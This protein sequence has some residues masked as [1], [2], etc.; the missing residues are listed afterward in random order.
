MPNAH[1]PVKAKCTALLFNVHTVSESRNLERA[2]R[3]VLARKKRRFL[4]AKAASERFGWNYDTY[5]QHERGERGISRA[6][7]DYARAY[8]VPPGWLLTGEGPSPFPED[9]SVE[10]AMPTDKGREGL[11][12]VVP[13]AGYVGA[14]AA[15]YL[16]EG[17]GTTGLGYVRAPRGIGAVEALTVRGDSMYPAYKDGDTIYFGGEAVELP[18][19]IADEYVVKLAD[20]R[21][22]LKEVVPV[23][24]GHYVLQSHNAP[25]IHD[26]EIIEAH[27]VRWIQR[28]RKSRVRLPVLGEP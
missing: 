24:N 12:S 9:E 23:G 13:E 10:N 21:I 27:E 15:V 14:G 3:L 4:T 8:R 16:F 1:W 5:S 18:I 26:A 7:Y 6:A 11:F 17:T 25:P 2:A 19:T 22:L 28:K 20:G